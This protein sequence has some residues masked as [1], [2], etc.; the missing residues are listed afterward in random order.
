MTFSPACPAPRGRPVDH[1]KD[2]QILQAAGRLF[3]REGLQ[4]TTME[5][6]AKEANVSKLTLYRRYPDK[7]MLFTEII[8]ERCEHYVPQ[9]IFEA[10]GSSAEDALTRFGTGLL[11]LITSEDGV[12][13]SR[14]LTAEARHNSDMCQLFFSSGPQRV[15]NGLQTLMKG[16]CASKRIACTN[17]SEAA[18]MFSALI[19]GADMNKQ[20]SMH[21]RPTPTDDEIHAYVT[22]AVAFFLK[23]YR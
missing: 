10:N 17:P 1:R 21:L 5:Q 15:K 9:E 14:V 2:E 19:V 18:E 8:S 20:C 3:M 6:I 13:L 22:R 11:K 12:N 23:A 16:L 4:G 7:N